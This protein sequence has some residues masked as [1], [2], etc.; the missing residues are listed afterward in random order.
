MLNETA[1]LHFGGKRR[2]ALPGWALDR[3]VRSMRAGRPPASDL[4]GPSPKGLRAHENEAVAPRRNSVGE[5]YL[6]TFATRALSDRV[7]LLSLVTKSRTVCRDRVSASAF[8]GPA[9]PLSHSRFDHGRPRSDLAA[10]GVGAPRDHRQLQGRVVVPQGAGA[11]GTAGR[12]CAI[13][14]MAKRSVG[15]LE[16]LLGARQAAVSQQLA[17][18]R[19]EGLVRGRRDGKTIYYS[20]GDP[21]VR[22]LVEALHA[23]FSEADAGLS[24]AIAG[25]LGAL[26][27]VPERVHLGEVAVRRRA[28]R[29]RGAP[30]RCAWKRRS[31]LALAPRSA[32]S[33]ID[34]EMPREVGHHEQQVADLLRHA[35]PGRRR[36]APRPA[37]AVSS[38]ILSSTGRG[39]GPVEADA[40]GALLQLHARVSAGRPRGTPSS[41]LAAPAVARRA[42]LGRLD[43]LPVARLL[44]RRLVAARVAEDVRVAADHLVADRRDH[45]GEVEARRPPRPCGRGRPPAAAGRR[46]RPRRSAMSPRSMASATS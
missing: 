23:L 37:R 31:N 20:L 1:T 17:R 30:P 18:L 8:L 22:L 39:V 41:A 27:R 15:E 40:R 14:S 9:S 5:Y 42:A 34:V 12:S 43:R 19:H 29:R 25:A 3:N 21:K 13:S 44:V 16:S 33:G 38:A 24:A 32:A 10:D 4:R 6:A 28:A 26:R 7:A 35:R 45:V 2:G 11:R 46:A 36:R